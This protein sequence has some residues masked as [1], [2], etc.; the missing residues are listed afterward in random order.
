VLRKE[1][2]RSSRYTSFTTE[3][4]IARRF[5]SASDNRFVRKVALAKLRELESHG[6]IKIWGPDAV[7]QALREGPKNLAK[8]AA[9]VRAAMRRNR[10]ILIEGQVAEGVLELVN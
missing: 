10:E 6:I 3:T 1:S 4:R 5:T 2:R 8:Q 9:D 7:Y